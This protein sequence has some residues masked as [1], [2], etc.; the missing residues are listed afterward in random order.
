MYAFHAV[1]VTSDI[2]RNAGFTEL[3]EGKIWPE[4]SCGDKYYVTRNDSS[5]VAFTV[6]GKYT[7][8]NGIKIIGAHTD[9]PNLAL[10]PKTRSTK[11]KY[12]RV[13]VQCYGGG[14]W[15]TWFD[16][17]LTVAGRVVV[18]RE[19]LEKRFVKIDKPI[20]RIPSLAIHL[21][22]G[23]ERE[24]FA[25]NKERHV[26]PLIATELASKIEGADGAA[27]SS[28][29]IPLMKLIAS[30]VDC[31]EEEI[32]DY[33]LSVI[34]TQA[35]T[36][37]GVE[38]EFI[39]SARLDNLISCF[40]ATKALIN[41]LNNMNED[42]MIRM[43]CLFDHE[44]VGSSSP[45]GAGGTLIPDVIEYIVNNKC[46]RATLVANSFLLSVDG[47]H[48]LHPNY[49]E[50]HEDNHRPQLH[51]GPVI[52]YN[53]NTRYAT[54]GLTAAIVKDVAKKGEV[55]I[56]EFVVKNDSPCGS[57]IGPILSTLSG[58]KT[59]DIGNAM[60]SMH[61]VREMCGTVD[62]YYLTKL[63]ES[64]FENYAAV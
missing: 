61:S 11:D 60:L 9:S 20:L 21:T 22:S 50:K 56:Q 27:K 10:K 47:A 32:V 6:G 18:K 62:I 14:L 54:N 36:I 25:P 57:T 26:I 38:D 59:A 34:D 12:E 31:K 35:A 1:K 58:I 64:F 45:Q 30:A 28:H 19:T 33:D 15:H 24:S 5:I 23:T 8:G 17:D 53:A 7:S 4:L 44:E 37:G 40:C 42:S 16:R 52:K 63:I 39:F 43:V 2:L 49:S 51:L 41:T 13:A 29:C 55:P 3:T 46:L 48:A